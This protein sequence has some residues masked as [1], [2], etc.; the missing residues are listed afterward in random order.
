MNEGTSFGSVAIMLFLIL[1]GVDK[2]NPV[3]INTYS[4]FRCDN[5]FDKRMRCDG[6][7][8]HVGDIE[9]MVNSS[10]STIHIKY[11]N[12]LDK[13]T[14]GFISEI[15][16]T[17]IY[18]KC[19]YMINYENFSCGNGGISSRTPRFHKDNGK[20]YMETFDE[21]NN[22]KSSAIGGIAGKLYRS[23][24][25]PSPQFWIEDFINWF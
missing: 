19:S 4:I 24:I 21:E 16:P 22:Y 17:G 5:N 11:I 18:E 23:G 20:F 8:S 12:I 15:A 3:S 14:Y 6:K 13:D 2:L 10:T 1:L 25:T 9:L 7:Y